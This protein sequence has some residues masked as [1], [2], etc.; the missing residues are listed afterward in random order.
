[1]NLGGS[2]CADGRRC[3]TFTANCGNVPRNGSVNVSG[4]GCD[5]RNSAGTD[6]SI[7]SFSVTGGGTFFQWSASISRTGADDAAIGQARVSLNCPSGARTG[8]GTSVSYTHL[9]LPTN[10][11]V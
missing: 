10:Y 6:F 1:M 7:N 2:V 3:G 8:S 9:T 5:A 11:S 4:T